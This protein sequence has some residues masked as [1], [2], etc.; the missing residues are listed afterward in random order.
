MIGNRVR[1][2]AH[3]IGPDIDTCLVGPVNDFGETSPNRVDDVA[4]VD[5]SFGHGTGPLREL[6]YGKRGLAPT[7]RSFTTVTLTCT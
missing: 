1:M 7:Q 4:R 5:D 6:F 2:P 3:Y